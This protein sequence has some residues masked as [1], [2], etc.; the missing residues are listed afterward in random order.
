MSKKYI[1]S[2]IREQHGTSTTTVLGT[3]Q[4]EALSDELSANK[5]LSNKPLVNTSRPAKDTPVLVPGTLASL[6][7]NTTGANTTG[8]NTSQ[9][10]ASKFTDK[11]KQLEN[12]NYKPPE[13]PIDIKSDIDFP[14]LGSSS[15]AAKNIV[16]VVDYTP[17]QNF[18]SLAKGWAKKTADAEEDELCRREEESKQRERELIMGTFVRHRRIKKQDD[19]DDE[20]EDY[21]DIYDDP[22]SEYSSVPEGDED[23]L[24]SY[25][26]EETNSQGRE[27]NSGLGNERRHHDDLY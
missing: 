24:G 8:T 11:Q 10:F 3:N 1:P 22:D 4:F 17:K 23:D 20:E 6:T 15:N 2:F 25:D 13:K 7:A 18:A 5:T 19:E 9:S 27:L 26:D 16:K 12:P 14:T 21:N